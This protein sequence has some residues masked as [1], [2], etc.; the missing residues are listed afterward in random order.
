M[1]STILLILVV[2][3]TGCASSRGPD[4]AQPP[5]RYSVPDSNLK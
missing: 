4:P 5:F 2:V 1:R 3:L